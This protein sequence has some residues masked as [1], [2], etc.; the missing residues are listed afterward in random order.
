[1]LDKTNPVQVLFFPTVDNTFKAIEKQFKV[2]P[3][4]T[5]YSTHAIE[6]EVTN[7]LRTL[8][9]A[10]PSQYYTNIS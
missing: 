2:D 7:K 5:N 1:M 6:Y 4:Y 9:A 3:E 10:N 8:I